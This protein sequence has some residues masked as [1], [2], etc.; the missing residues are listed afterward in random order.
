MDLAGI[1]VFDTI[2]QQTR[3]RCELLVGAGLRVIRQYANGHT[4]GLGGKAHVDDS[5]PGC[6]TLLYYPMAEWN[7]DWEGETVFYDECGEVAVS[8]RPRPNRAVLFDSRILH[9][10]RAPSRACPALRVTVAY[11]LE[12]IPFIIL[13]QFT[14]YAGAVGDGDGWAYGFLPAIT[15]SLRRCHQQ[16]F[17]LLIM[18]CSGWTNTLWAQRFLNG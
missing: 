8:V 3:G 17:Y 1:V 7:D 4:Y 6:Y 13:D 10:G 11:T 14:S 15:Y 12:F 2:W 16:G 5:R 18:V 9:A